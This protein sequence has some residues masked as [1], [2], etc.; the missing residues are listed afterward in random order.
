VCGDTYTQ[1]GLQQKPKAT[2][3]AAAEAAEA[4]QQD[5]RTIRFSIRRHAARS[6]PAPRRSCSNVTFWDSGEPLQARK[7]AVQRKAETRVGCEWASSSLCAH[8]APLARCRR[9]LQGKQALQQCDSSSSPGGSVM[10]AAVRYQRAVSS[11]AIPALAT[12]PGHL[13]NGV[14]APLA[15]AAL[16][17]G[18][19][20][21][22]TLLAPKAKVD[23]RPAGQQPVA[24][25]QLMW[26]ALF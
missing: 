23:V 3:A 2:L 6:I 8:T 20:L 25:Q 17:S 19:N 9:Q 4:K 13:S 1:A 12:A 15:P 18:I 14:N 22:H 21:L 24:G 26:R 10:L 16:A 11:S 5:Q 7:S